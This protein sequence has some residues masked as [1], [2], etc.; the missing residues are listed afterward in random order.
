VAVGGGHVFYAGSTASTGG[1]LLT[2][3]PAAG[4]APSVL[5][6]PAD[7]NSIWMLA[8]DAENVYFA[9]TDGVV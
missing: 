2:C 1:A 8:T 9:T 6:T 5:F 4:G 3:V 7:G